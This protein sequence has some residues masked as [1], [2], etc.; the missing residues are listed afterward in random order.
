VELSVVEQCCTN[1]Q[2]VRRHETY[3]HTTNRKIGWTGLS[4]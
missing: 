3:S 2:E 4:G 1:R